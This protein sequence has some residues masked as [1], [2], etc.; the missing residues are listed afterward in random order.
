MMKPFSRVS[1]EATTTR[2]GIE[3]SLR[4]QFL[5]GLAADFAALQSNETAWANEQAERTAWDAAT[6][7]P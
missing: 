4:R 3:V 6:T 1:A 5:E 2:R 7:V